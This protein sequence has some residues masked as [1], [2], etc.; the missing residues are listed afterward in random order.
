MTV[1]KRRKAKTTARRKPAGRAGAPSRSRARMAA[2]IQRVLASHGIRGKLVQVQVKPT[3]PARAARMRVPARRAAARVPVVPC[4][5]GT[6]RRVVCFFRK[7]T[8][9]CEERCVPV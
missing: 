4:P 9:V 7:G 6:V 3:T 1:P 5:A 8:F 2:D